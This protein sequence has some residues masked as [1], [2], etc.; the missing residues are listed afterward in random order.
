MTHHAIFRGSNAPGSLRSVP[1]A[2]LFHP[3][4]VP[5]SAHADSPRGKPVAQVGGS[6]WCESEDEP[7]ES[8]MTQ[9]NHDVVFGIQNDLEE[10][11]ES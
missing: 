8:A 3:D 4:D 5:D 9:A 6:C 11:E 10:S 7:A 1:G 2:T